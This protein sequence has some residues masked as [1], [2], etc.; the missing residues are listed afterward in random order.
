MGA[1]GHGTARAAFTEAGWQISPW[2]M[3]GTCGA[4]QP[5]AAPLSRATPVP[6]PPPSPASSP[7]AAQLVPRG[8]EQCVGASGLGVRV[9][10]NGHLQKL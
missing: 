2:D 9:S 6:S 3:A 10:V 5:T 1:K 8:T 7:H 4:G